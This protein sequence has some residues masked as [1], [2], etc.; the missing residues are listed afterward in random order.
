MSRSNESRNS[1]AVLEAPTGSAGVR[2]GGVGARQGG[3]PTSPGGGGYLGTCIDP[4]SGQN[5][6]FE[7]N[8]DSRLDELAAMGLPAIWLRVATL[9]G[10]DAFLAM[11]RVLDSDPS[12]RGDDGLLQIKMRSYRSYLRFQRNRYIEA[13]SRQGKTTAEIQERV[14]MDLLERIS[15]RHILRIMSGR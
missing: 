9:L 2:A 14:K 8:R 13:L 12:L 1:Q 15:R 6:R 10:F 5:V 11:W 7:K 3:L 4:N